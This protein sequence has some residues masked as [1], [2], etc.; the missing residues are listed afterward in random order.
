M[1]NEEPASR[2]RGPIPTQGALVLLAV[3]VLGNI[4]VVRVTMGA[5]T[6][7]FWAA[8]L[9]Q[10]FSACVWTGAVWL[11]AVLAWRTI[12]VHRHAR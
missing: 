12:L 8:A 2:S 5:S 9:S 6:P 1:D 11:G 3:G 7:S 4:L 10:I